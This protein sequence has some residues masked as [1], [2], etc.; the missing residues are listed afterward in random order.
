MSEKRFIGR[1]TAGRGGQYPHRS[2]A[3]GT[4]HSNFAAQPLKAYHHSTRPGFMVGGAGQVLAAIAQHYRRGTGGEQ[5]IKGGTFFD[6]DNPRIERVT[7]MIRR[8]V[9]RA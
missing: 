2:C 9:R 4:R 1:W 3:R 7:A 6:I 5:N 8:M